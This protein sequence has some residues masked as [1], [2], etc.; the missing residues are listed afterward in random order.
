MNEYAVP[1]IYQNKKN[2]LD[3]IIVS[4]PGSKSITNRAMLLAAMAHGE[5]TLKGVLFSDDSRHFLN[6]IESLG[7]QTRIDEAN[8]VLHIIGEGGRIPKDNASIYVGSAGT[9]ARFLTAYLGVSK[10]SYYLDASAQ[11]R[12]RPMAPLLQSLTDLGCK[13]TYAKEEGHFPFTL[14]SNGFQQNHISVNIDNSSQF[15]SALM[16]T[17][18]LSE[19]GLSLSLTG[20]HGMSYVH[21]TQKMMEQFGIS[22]LQQEPDLFVIEP[23]QH[24][25]PLSYQIEPDVSAACYFYA[26]VPLLNI[27]VLVSHV[28]SDSLQ[29]DIAFLHILTKMGCSLEETPDGI[30]LSPPESGIYEGVDVNMSSC[31]DQAITLAAIAPFAK[32]KTV[33]RGIGHIRFQECNRLFGIVN[34]LRNMGICC[35]E[36]EDSIT[37]YPGMPKAASLDTYDDHRMAMGFTLTGLRSQKI[38]IKDPGCCRKT[39]ENYFQ[40]MESVIGKI[41]GKTS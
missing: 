24:V 3:P 27:P 9:A 28:T 10:G 38:I 18:V 17:S 31:S 25:T 34:N 22:I 6:C 12:A 16:I 30:L 23:G 29:G 33:I 4:V 20:S 37:I 40:V 35:E 5:S 41:Q 21:M 11:M 1:C 2:N 19:S 39:F 15:L 36:T 8:K 14:H 32:S 26:L 7:F 13:I